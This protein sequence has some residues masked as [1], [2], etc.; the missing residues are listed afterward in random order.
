VI[1]AVYSLHAPAEL[2]FVDDFSL[3]VRPALIAAG[4]SFLAFFV[5]DGRPNNFPA[6]PVRENEHVMVWIAGF[7]DA[8]TALQWSADHSALEFLGADA[9]SLKDPP[10]TLR[11]VPTAR[12][13]LTGASQG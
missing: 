13:S 12:S 2:D 9:P 8:A 5:T 6:L 4:A 7:A 11:L 3:M 1:A 10:Q